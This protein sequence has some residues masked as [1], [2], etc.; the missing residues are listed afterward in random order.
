M[1]YLVL[2]LFFVIASCVFSC[3]SIDSSQRGEASH[4][5]G[6]SVPMAMIEDIAYRVLQENSYSAFAQKTREVYVARSLAEATAISEGNESV[7]SL[8]E[9]I[10]FSKEAVLFAF[11]GQFNTG[12]YGVI[13][14]NIKREKKGKVKVLFSISSPEPKAIVTQAFTSPSL[15]I[16]ISAEKGDVIEASFVN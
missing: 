1:K 15:I 5:K 7:I 8:C 10:D 11:G 2:S 4:K 6:G 9:N 12:G 14:K 13:V 16:A 3:Q